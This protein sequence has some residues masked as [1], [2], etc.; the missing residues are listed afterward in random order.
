MI[1]DKKRGRF[2]ILE[3]NNMKAFLKYL[4]VILLLI[5][6]VFFVV[7]KF[8]VQQ[9]WLLVCGLAFEVVGILTYIILNKRID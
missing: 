2:A 9:N 8:A 6:V 1:S 4:G 7:Y 5:G 3:Y